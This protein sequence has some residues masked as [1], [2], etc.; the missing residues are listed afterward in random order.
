MKTIEDVIRVLLVDDHQVMR[1]GTRVLLE[2]VPDIQVVAEADTQEAAVGMAQQYKPTIALLDIKLREGN[3]L[4]AAR[5]IRQTVPETRILILSAH[6]H[7]Q[8]V[9]AALR[10]GVHGYI[11]KDASSNEV[12]D[13]IRKVAGGGTV[14]GPSIAAKIVRSF[15]T[16]GHLSHTEGAAVLS[17][18]EMDVLE[19][20]AAGV[21]NVDIGGRL[22]ISQ[23][24]IETHITNI[25]KKLQ[26]KTRTEAVRVAISRGIVVIDS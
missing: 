10:I 2:Q 21:K 26:A 9:R 11:L 4:E 18:R 19:L 6:E 14:L 1:E 5:T 16:D 3:G 7:D 25:L 12:V 13:A 20:M 15:S 23:K 8:Y 17:R 22:G 24:T